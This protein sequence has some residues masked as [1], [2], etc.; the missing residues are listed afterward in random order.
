[1]SINTFDTKISMLSSLLLP[2]IRILS[3]FFFLFL[4]ILSNSLIIPGVREKTKVKLPPAFPT[5]APTALAD[6]MI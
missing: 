5:G 6:E 1:M 4:V 3:C 2:N